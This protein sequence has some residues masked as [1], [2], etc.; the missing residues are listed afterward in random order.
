MS[1][2][3]ESSIYDDPDLTPTSFDDYNVTFKNVGDRV[4]GRVIRMD[5]INTRYGK[6][7]KYWLWDIDR[8]IERTMLAGAMDLWSQLH[9]LRPQADD[10]LTIE[11][12]AIEGQRYVFNVEV[13]Q[14]QELPF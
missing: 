4:H 11:L 5:R 13:S 6:V 3:D 2:S 1:S 8:Q 7:A 14:E 10:V 9:K 12:V